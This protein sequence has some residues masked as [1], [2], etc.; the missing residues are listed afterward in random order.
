MPML[1]KTPTFWI[2]P[3]PSLMTSEFPCTRGIKEKDLALKVPRALPD[4][5]GLAMVSLFP[6]CSYNT[7]LWAPKHIAKQSCPCWILLVHTTQRISVAWP[8]TFPFCGCLLEPG[9]LAALTVEPNSFLLPKSLASTF[10][11]TTHNTPNVVPLS[12][13]SQLWQL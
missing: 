7:L 13:L 9:G 11:S 1:M 3:F 4:C 5:T 8:N 6:P 12:S 2:L 10:L